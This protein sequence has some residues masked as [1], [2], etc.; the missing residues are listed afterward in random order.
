MQEGLSTRR[1]AKGNISRKPLR[2]FGLIFLVACLSALLFFGTHLNQSLARGLNSLSERLGADVMVVPAGYKAN[3]E[4]ILLKG[5]PSTFY[6]PAEIMEELADFP[7]IQAASPQ[8][9]VATLSASCCSYPVQIIGIDPASDFLIEPWLADSLK[10]E[11]PDG[12]AM[13]GGNIIGEAGDEVHF[14]D[15]S[16]RIAGRLEKTGMGFDSTVFVTM[17]T[18]LKLARAS[19]RMGANPA[20]AG[21]QISCVMI[22]VKPGIDSAKLASLITEKLSDQGVF[23]MFGKRIINSVGANLALLSRYINVT[24]LALWLV[25]F[26]VLALAFSTMINERKREMAV[27]RVLG[28]EQR[29]IRNIFLYES[30]SLCLYGGLIGLLLGLVLSLAVAP[31]LSKS[32]SIPF[33]SLGLVENLALAGLTILLVLVI[34]PLAAIPAIRR[35]SREDPCRYIRD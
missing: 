29:K 24:M 1:L 33:R 4:S 26:L 6:L 21:A 18:A 7:G 10:H 32:L 5:E 9:Y 8:L 30:T 14:F 34:G 25:S 27:L 28:A 3:L 2:S 15:Q 16:L 11:L 17:D 31:Q 23:A 19:E 22:K 20:A 12:E 35:F 13:V